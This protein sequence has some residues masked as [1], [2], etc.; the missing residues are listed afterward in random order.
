M[1]GA[2]GLDAV[3]DRKRIAERG[4][5]DLGFRAPRANER[6]AAAERDSAARGTTD[7]LQELA[8]FDRPH[9]GLLAFVRAARGLFCG[10]EPVDLPIQRRENPR[11]GNESQ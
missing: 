10:T 7:E 5:R 9:Q 1:V 2:P 8:P 11:Y 4:E 3:R 6:A